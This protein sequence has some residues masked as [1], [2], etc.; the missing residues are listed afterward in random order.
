[1]D[2]DQGPRSDPSE[3][4]RGDSALAVSSRRRALD[5]LRTAVEGGQARPILITGEPGAGKTWLA[6]QLACLLPSCW[7][8]IRVD[9]TRAMTALDFLQLIG[10]SLGLPLAEGLGAA[11]AR[12]D[13][14]LYDDDLDGRRWLLVVD[15]AHRG[16]PVVWDE[17]QALVNQS[18]RPGGF[19][20]L[21]VLGDTELV[22]AFATRGF[23][24]FASRLRVHLHLSPLDLDEARELL[25]L[26]GQDHV[27]AD[28]ALEELHRDSRGNPGGLLRLAQRRP[29]PWRLIADPTPDRASHDGVSAWPRFP[30]P[31][32]RNSNGQEQPETLDSEHAAS[33]SGLAAAHPDQRRAETPSLMPA[34]PPIRVEDG[35]VEVGWDGDLESELMEPK[36][37]TN[38]AETRLADDRSFNE[39]LIE[40]RY[41]ALQAWSEWT[42]SQKRTDGRGVA[43]ENHAARHAGEPA[44]KGEAP[45]T[46]EPSGSP[47]ASPAATP[48]GIRAEP[49]HAF[50]PYS[51]LFTRL[52][53]SKQP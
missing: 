17:I 11:R 9:L 32:T 49:Q 8:S 24:G 6:R 41:A 30:V 10:H 4:P 50:A 39:E 7:G 22:R 3:R 29:A 21:V 36:D 34:R 40:D 44:P 25:A 37:T 19:A 28:R 42:E 33:A 26:T 31:P 13:T 14:I 12:L 16:S 38:T 20:A 18:G 48:P 47:A 15:E 2:Q 46:E 51:Q 35:L 43:V 1:M 23:G 45:P 53:E 27:A 5:R 52:R